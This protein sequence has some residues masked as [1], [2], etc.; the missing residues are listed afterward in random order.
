MYCGRMLLAFAYCLFVVPLVLYSVVVIYRTP[1]ET[2][3]WL[4]GHTC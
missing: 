2:S 1:R 4:M 3:P